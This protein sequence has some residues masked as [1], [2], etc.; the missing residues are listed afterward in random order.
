MLALCQTAMYIYTSL[1]LRAVLAV[2]LRRNALH[3]ILHVPTMLSQG[4]KAQ[5]SSQCHA[6]NQSLYASFRKC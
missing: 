6:A 4:P 1:M 2:L 5:S 3:M